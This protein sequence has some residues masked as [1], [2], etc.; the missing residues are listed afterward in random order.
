[1]EFAFS[2]LTLRLRGRTI[3]DRLGGCLLPGEVTVILGANGAGKSSLLACLAGLRTPSSGSIAL[4]NR[5]LKGIGHHER[6]R[7]V[8]LLPQKAEV[9]WDIDAQALVALGRLPHRGRWGESGPDREA[10]ARAMSATDIEHLSNRKVLR[11]SGGE[12]AR[13]LL[14]RVLAGQPRWLL[15]DEPLASLDPAHQLDVLDRLADCARDGVGVVAVLH[16]LTQAARVADRVVLMK[17]GRILASGD[18]D[19][20]L[21]PVLIREAFGIE[22]YLGRDGQGQSL[23]VPVGRSR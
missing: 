16:D 9:H 12:Q 6:A 17:Q 22:V 2:D 4:G 23:I 8:G 15:A 5:P 13:V 18:R 11:L 20:V 19:A 10:I 1:M 21:T 3:L 14:A 7:L